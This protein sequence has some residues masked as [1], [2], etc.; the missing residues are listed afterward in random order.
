MPAPD[1]ESDRRDFLCRAARL[2]ACA[3]GLNLILPASA[4]SGGSIPRKNPGLTQAACVEGVLVYTRDAEHRLIGTH[5]AGL[6]AAIWERIDGY[7]SV[8]HIVANLRE[9][10]R[11]RSVDRRNVTA[12]VSAMREAGVSYCGVPLWELIRYPS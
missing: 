10:S 1:G 9:D 12:E 4:P 3:A 7:R 11:F 5:I 8:A 2:V 6:G